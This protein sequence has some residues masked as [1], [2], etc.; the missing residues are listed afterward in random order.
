MLNFRTSFASLSVEGYI[1]LNP[2]L[3]IVTRLHNFGLLPETERLKA[4][5]SIR[6]L[7]VEVPDSSFLREDVR[8]L[9]TNEELSN[10][11]VSVEENL[12]PDLDY[13]VENWRSDYMGDCE[14]T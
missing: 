8:N 14:P 10:I 5:D 4:V 7:A 11:L 1:F 3:T 13:E 9:M 6:C 2:N 12:L